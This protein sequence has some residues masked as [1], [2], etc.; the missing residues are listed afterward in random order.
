[1]AVSGVG[2]G[3]IDVA[4]IVS[5]L[6]TIEQQPLVKMQQNLSGIQTKLSAWGKLQAAVSTLR[7]ATRALTRNETWQASKASSGDEASI[8]VG[9]GGNAA[10]GNY[11]LS[12][13]SLAQSQSVVSSTFAA[14]DTVI[15]GGSLQIQMGS[16]DATGSVFTGD[17]QRLVSINVAAGA[18]L[19]DIRSAINSANAGVSASILDD[20]TGKR[21]V[22]TSRAWRSPPVRTGWTVSS[23]V[24][25]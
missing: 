24:S 5:Q 16:I 17:P 6:M 20:G 7:D 15:G 21:L 14:S 19:A 23:R 25:R 10:A 8:A 13:Q 11:S 3:A 12:V 4:G 22:L 1:M 2:G 18:T 9:G